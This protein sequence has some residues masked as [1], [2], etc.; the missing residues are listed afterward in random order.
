[1][2]PPV[3]IASIHDISSATFEDAR[4]DAAMLDGLN[5]RPINLLVVPRHP[6]GAPLTE[7]RDLA[8][9]LV[10]RQGAGDEILL[11]GYEHRLVHPPRSRL[12]ALRIRAL[13]RNEGEF[14]TLDH[15]DAADRLREGR[16]ALEACGLRASGFAAPAYLLSAGARRAVAEAGFTHV[17]QLFSVW[18][19]ATRS[20]R[21]TP[22]LFFDPHSATTRRLT[23]FQST[24]SQHLFARHP[25]LRIVIHPPDL[26]D[27]R[28]EASLRAALARALQTRS[29][30]TYTSLLGR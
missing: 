10:A 14:A 8:A 2:A 6:G 21:F 27:P 9:W 23:M 16:A 26:K 30:T 20:M 11:H 18:F 25:L 29:P 1:M 15:R 22:A 12:A 17:P 5:V 3:L 4:A 19:P 28:T 13:S 24:L 7:A